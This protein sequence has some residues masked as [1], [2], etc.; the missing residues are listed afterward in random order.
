MSERR[1]RPFTMADAMGL[2]AAMTPGLL[3]LRIA[4][5]FGLFTG[6][7]FRTSPPGR[8]VVEYLSVGGGSVLLSLTI[9]LLI[10][11]AIRRDGVEGPGLVA[12]LGVLVALIL[13]LGHFV[14]GAM[15]SQGWT[16]NLIVPFYNLFGRLGGVAGPLIIGAWMALALVGRWRIIPTWTDRLGCFIGACWIL[17]WFYAEIYFL[18]VLPWLRWRG[19]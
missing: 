15:S 19:L 3:L 14:V 11:A 5:G 10:L 2:V 18:A 16:V 13:P 17:L 6:N 4:T 7:A 1:H 12:C 9:G 8:A